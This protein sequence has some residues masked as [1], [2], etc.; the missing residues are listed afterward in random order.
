[1]FLI[2]KREQPNNGWQ[3]GSFWVRSRSHP[4]W[5]FN[6]RKAIKKKTAR[7]D[8]LGW[9]LD[10]ADTRFDV[11]LETLD[12]LIK[13]LLLVVVGAAEDVD[14]LFG[15]IGLQESQQGNEVRTWW[16]VDLRRVQQ[17]RRSSRSRLL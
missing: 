6:V 17:G 3:A 16:G 11:G 8:L 14:G 4:T 13:E 9:I 2:A 5:K 1:M 15:S 12:G 10:E 7:W